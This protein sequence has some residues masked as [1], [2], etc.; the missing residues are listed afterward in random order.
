MI[1]IAIFAAGEGGGVQ[2]S[3]KL[4]VALSLTISLIVSVVFP[5][6]MRHVTNAAL[7]RHFLLFEMTSSNLF[8]L[9]LEGQMNTVS[10]SSDMQT[11]ALGPQFLLSSQG[12]VP[13]RKRGRPPIRKLEFQS[14]Y[15]EPLLPIKVPKKRGRKPGFKVSQ[16]RIMW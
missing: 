11:P 1:F 10:D 5:L 9:S 4:Y 7:G 13:G 12:K 16:S 3:T 2:Q 6:Q 8:L 15:V 14:C